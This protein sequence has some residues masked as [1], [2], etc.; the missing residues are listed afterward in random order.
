MEPFLTP[1]NNSCRPHYTCLPVLLPSSI[2]FAPV[3]T[4]CVLTVVLDA[5]FVDVFL[6]DFIT[7]GLLQTPT[8]DCLAYAVPII[9]EIFAQPL[10]HSEP[11]LQS[12]LISQKNLTA[13]GYPSK[14]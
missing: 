4:T 10:A 14:L 5:T 7:L 8:A 12:I 9:N 1:P 2:P 6:D 3:L 13:E 11:L